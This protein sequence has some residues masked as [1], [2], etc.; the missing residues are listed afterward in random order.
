MAPSQV[1]LLDWTGT[2]I[3]LPKAPEPTSQA[4][5]GRVQDRWASSVL[6]DVEPETL[7]RVARN[8]APLPDHM[9][10]CDKIY[11]DASFL[12][13]AEDYT[14]SIAGLEWDVLPYVDAPRA[15][16]KAEDQK[17]ADSIGAKLASTPGL[18]AYFEHLAWGDG[19][20][21]LAGA[22]TIWDVSTYLASRFE[23]VDAVRW[24]WASDNTL[25]LL[26][27][28]D[29]REGERLK[30]ANWTT[31]SRHPQNPRKNRMHKALSFF[32][33][34]T[35]FATID[36]LATSEKFGKPIP[37]AYFQDGADK[38]AVAEAVMQIGTEFA[39]VFPD[40]VK[41]EL[42]QALDMK[43]TIQQGLAQW[44]YDQATK[45]ITGHVLITEAKSGSGTLGGEGAQKTNLK[46]VKAGSG[47]VAGSVRQGYMRPL[48]YFHHGEKAAARVPYL[49][50]K[51]KP[52]ED[53]E[54]K[55]R[56]YVSWNE[57][58]AP[59]GLAIGQEHIKEA[60][61]VPDL[62]VRPTS[63]AQPSGELIAQIRETIK[64]LAAG[65]IGEEAAVMALKRASVPEEEALAVVAATQK[66]KPRV[67]EPAPE[68]DP[69]AP[70]PPAE[71][72]APLHRSTQA[73]KTPAIRTL[74]D[75]VA[76][77]TVIGAR[78][79]AGR[80]TEILAAAQQAAKDGK[81]VQ[82]FI[83][84]LFETYDSFETTKDA[85]LLAQASVVSEAIGAGDA[86]AR[87]K[88]DS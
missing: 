68:A 85:E 15:K 43:S 80:A 56:S 65:L 45:L 13:A 73:A 87:A 71:Q 82:E 69:P 23:L 50:F 52:A 53:E 63:A 1:T 21:P 79:D 61:G 75:V 30:A 25:R 41:I 38:D 55:A 2:P 74:S 81:T 7:A 58:L 88:G 8:T 42:L 20:Y 35:R 29:S 46:K 57:V 3:A 44:G 12:A 33:M 4:E 67:E 40:S 83:D 84:S 24:N 9:T 10:L 11:L 34:C 36:W 54:K 5:I 47:R 17:V 22:E 16:A 59:L 27:A 32:Y 66:N 39:G 18:D 14:G 86:V 37:I 28:L 48:T 6:R 76:A 51:V 77:S 64:D 49:V 72:R 60:A 78:G 62:V 70:V 19:L 31:H 26:T